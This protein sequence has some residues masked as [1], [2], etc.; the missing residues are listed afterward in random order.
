MYLAL[1][2]A[3]AGDRAKM[4]EHVSAYL[5]TAPASPISDFLRLRLAV[6]TGDEGTLAR[7]RERFDSLDISALRWIALTSQHDG[8]A[9]DDG[10][11]ALELLR[12]RA[13]RLAHRR[14]A[15][16][17]LHSMALLRGQ[18]DEA[19]ALTG[20]L[21]DGQPGSRSA[22][23]IRVLD[24]LYG[25]GD[26]AAAR[27]A[28]GRL[29]PGAGSHAPSH[30]DAC[31]IGQWGAWHEETRTARM[32]LRVLRDSPESAAG[33]SV[34]CS[35][36]VEAIGAVKRGVPEARRLVER[37]DSIVAVGPPLGDTRAYASLAIAR[38]YAALGDPERALASV[39][40]RPYLRGWPRYLGAYLR[41]EGRL[42]AATGDRE[43]AANAYRQYLTLRNFAAPSLAEEADSVRAE[44]GA[45]GWRWRGD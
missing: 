31:V 41:E 23:R 12:T 14:E 36:L 30:D 26:S 39:R 24:A 19:L 17:G 20:E 37:T 1:L 22:E 34:A 42:A 40:R 2:E 18:P 10:N 44:L 8:I 45:L 43:G 9:V 6:A 5:R 7:M 11:R 21:D 13:A 38:M 33:T 25:S 3:R 32:G 4:R 27:V 35:A 16:L 28:I 29:L 15:V